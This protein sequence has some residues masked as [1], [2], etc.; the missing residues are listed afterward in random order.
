MTEPPGIQVFSASEN[1]AY[2]QERVNAKAV[3]FGDVVRLKFARTLTGASNATARSLG[4]RFYP[5]ALSAFLEKKKETDGEVEAAVFDCGMGVYRTLG[6][7]TLWFTIVERWIGFDWSA[8]HR[9]HNRVDRLYKSARD[10][11]PARKPE[12]G[13][14]TRVQKRLE[15]RRRRDIAARTPHVEEAYLL[16]T[17]IFSA[18]NLEKLARG[19]PT[20]AAASKPSPEFGQRIALV[21]PQVDHAAGDLDRAAQRTAR[22][23]YLRGISVGVVALLVVCLAGGGILAIADVPAWTGIALLGGG[24]GA[25]VSVFQRITT[26]RLR[27]DP[28]TGADM[29]V[30]L[31]SVRPFIGAAFGMALF[32]LLVGGWLLEVEMDSKL[33]FYAALGFLAGFNERFAQDML[34]Q[35]AQSALSRWMPPAETADEAE[36]PARD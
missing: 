28:T 16:M 10:Q 7:G 5:P 30:K 35:S 32:A 9:L 21:R 3:S 12:K 18:V 11:W 15:R 23:D 36:T 24:V 19:E 4:D 8:A 6:T 13:D 33:G 26:N 2:W 22:E 27:L 20:R 1:E 14:S 31:G 34:S 29:L 17:S 25:V